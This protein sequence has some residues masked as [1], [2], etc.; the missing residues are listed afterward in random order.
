MKSILEKMYDGEVFPPERKEA[1]A[2]RFH[3]I[4]AAAMKQYDDF[5]S[6][7]NEEQKRDFCEMMDRDWELMAEEIKAS[8]IDGL[9]CGI[10]ILTA[11]LSG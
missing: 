9:R 3:E 11:A 6:T 4:R 10:R 2:E 7:L 5:I 1:A 8:Y